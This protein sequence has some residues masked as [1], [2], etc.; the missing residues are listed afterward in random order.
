M[1]RLYRHFFAVSRPV[2]MD[3]DRVNKRVTLQPQ[4]KK[5]SKAGQTIV[6]GSGPRSFNLRSSPSTEHTNSIDSS[7]NDSIVLVFF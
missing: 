2:A 7:N 3:N 4:E 5:R 1:P 6:A